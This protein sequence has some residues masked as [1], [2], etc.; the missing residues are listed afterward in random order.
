MG[1]LFTL[2]KSFFL[3]MRWEKLDMLD[4][5]NKTKTVKYLRVSTNE[6]KQDINN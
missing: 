4:E 1:W 5:K 6:D 2:N 3:I